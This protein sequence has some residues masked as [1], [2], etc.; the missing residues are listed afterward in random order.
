MIE[1]L[2]ASGSFW[3]APYSHACRAGNFLF[4]TGQMPVD[5]ATGDYVPNEIEL[6][7]RR[8]MDNLLLVLEEA[9]MP[10]TWPIICPPAPASGSPPSPAARESK[11]T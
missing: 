3:E 8:V 2:T 11:W 5:P 9:G 1:R 10:N 6:Q 7:S 4:V